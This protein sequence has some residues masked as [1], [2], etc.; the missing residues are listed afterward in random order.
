[1]S[2]GDEFRENSEAVRA[3]LQISQAVIQ[4]MAANSSACKA[5]CVTLV[6]AILVLVA[7]KG[8]PKFALMALIPT[9]LFWALDAYYLALEKMFR[10]SYNSFIDK[11]HKGKI[12]AEDLY[13]IKPGGELPDAINAAVKSF[14][15]WP[16]YMTL[17][18]MVWIAKKLVM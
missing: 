10:N 17:L 12:T 3:H 6:S 2:Q 7:D 4:R 11:L 13:A 9:A 1:M 18:A 15:I 16:F 8:K 5:W 14:S